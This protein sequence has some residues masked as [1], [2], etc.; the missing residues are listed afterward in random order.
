MLT[1]GCGNVMQDDAAVSGGGGSG[2]GPPASETNEAQTPKKNND[3]ANGSGKLL[4]GRV[5]NATTAQIGGPDLGG[6]AP[7]NPGLT[8]DAA[9]SQATV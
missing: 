9:G 3:G 8:M 6:I 7:V 1:Y 5:V 2:F 4:L